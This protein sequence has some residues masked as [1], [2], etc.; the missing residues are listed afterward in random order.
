MNNDDFKD[1]PTPMSELEVEQFAHFLTADTMGFINQNAVGVELEAALHFLSM[2][3]GH[4]VYQALTNKPDT[5]GYSQE[6]EVDYAFK[7][8]KNMK[9]NIEGALAM[10]FKGAMETFSGKNSDFYCQVTP[11]PAPINKRPC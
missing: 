4:L 9:E 8:Y 3:V 7:S 1:N 10:G 6:E 5:A 2:F 11:V